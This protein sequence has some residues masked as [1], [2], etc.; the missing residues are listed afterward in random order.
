MPHAMQSS[1]WTKVVSVFA[2]AQWQLKGPGGEQR[3]HVISGNAATGLDTILRI[4]QPHVFE[5]RNIEIRG[6][7]FVGE[8]RPQVRVM[9]R[10]A[11]RVHRVRVGP[12]EVSG[13]KR[14]WVVDEKGQ[15]L[16]DVDVLVEEH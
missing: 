16:E 8:K 2:N 15:P 7:R 6:N 13:E 12:N 1:V 5:F 11:G 3:P 14:P 9:R 4:D 10:I